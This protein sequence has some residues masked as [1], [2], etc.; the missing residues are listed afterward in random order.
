MMEFQATFRAVVLGVALV[1]WPGFAGRVWADQAMA[2]GAPAAA[3]EAVAQAV[4]DGGMSFAGD[5]A[6]TQ[7]PRDLGRVCSKLVA[8]QSG[9]YAFQTGRAFSE[10]SQW[11]FVA[12]DTDG[13]QVVG[14]VPLSNSIADASIP[15]PAGGSASP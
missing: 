10:F 14:T 4:S 2:N 8:A 13:W 3:V 15:W 6:S 12:Q 5:C 1:A 11:V 7:S 9:V